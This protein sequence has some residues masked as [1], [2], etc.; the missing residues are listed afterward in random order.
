M[1]MREATQRVT[2]KRPGR[3]ATGNDSVISLSMPPEVRCK[4]ENWACT[5]K[6][7]LSKAIIRLIERGLAAPQPA[8]A[9]AA[10]DRAV[11]RLKE[12]ALGQGGLGAPQPADPYI[13][14]DRAVAQL[15]DAP[16]M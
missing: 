4:I 14:F 12:A 11:A 7:T 9:Y 2:P 6:L 1:D 8:D 13:V 16:T 5:E 3:S 15:K 10:F